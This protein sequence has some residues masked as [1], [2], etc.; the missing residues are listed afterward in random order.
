MIST[1][2]ARPPV[3][4]GWI[5]VRNGC[6]CAT[7]VLRVP[8]FP[9]VL[10]VCLPAPLPPAPRVFAREARV[11]AAAERTR[12][13]SKTLRESIHADWLRAQFPELAPLF[14]KADYHAKY[15]NPEDAA[16]GQ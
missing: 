10:N 16:H 4:Q 11:D 9:R 8:H 13:V 3:K 7:R 15:F 5:V 2:A 6:P 12:K 1:R 14:S